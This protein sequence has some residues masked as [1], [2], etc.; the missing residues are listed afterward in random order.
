MTELRRSIGLG[1]K[2]KKVAR[3]ARQSVEK[4]GF[5]GKYRRRGKMFERKKL[6]SGPCRRARVGGEGLLGKEKKRSKGVR[7]KGGGGTS[8]E[9]KK[10]C[11]KKVIS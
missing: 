2:G 9:E 8:G 10:G 5:R 6:A 7:G 4:R 3:G 1:E 11:A